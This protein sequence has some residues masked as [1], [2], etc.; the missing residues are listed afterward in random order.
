[1][2]T[3]VK[4]TIVNDVLFCSR[5]DSTVSLAAL[6]LFIRCSSLHLAPFRV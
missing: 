6:R 3:N 2:G 5:C 1:M 4:K